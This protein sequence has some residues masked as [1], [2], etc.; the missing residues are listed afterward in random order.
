MIVGWP[1]RSVEQGT[2]LTKKSLNP[3]MPSLIPY[4]KE[5]LSAAHNKSISVPFEQVFS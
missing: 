4:I 3:Y 1:E 2:L 5:H